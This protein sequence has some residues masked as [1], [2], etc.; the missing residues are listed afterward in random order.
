M[1]DNITQTL[2]TVCA[3]IFKHQQFKQCQDALQAFSS[4]LSSIPQ[5]KCATMHEQPEYDVSWTSPQSA[6]VSSSTGQVHGELAEICPQLSSALSISLDPST[7]FV[8]DFAFR[9]L[10]GLVSFCFSDNVSSI[11]EAC[12]RDD[13][14]L[15]HVVLP[16]NLKVVLNEA[17]YNCSKLD[18][19]LHQCIQLEAIADDAFSYCKSLRNVVLPNGIEVVGAAFQCCGDLDVVEIPSTLLALDPYAFAGTHI[20]E[21]KGNVALQKFQATFRRYAYERHM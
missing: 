17:F 11:S 7:T 3:G 4:C 18:V 19:D 12:F 1:T 20:S 21:L 8:G 9:R 6:I 14:N 5:L 13:I 2:K 16:K 10:S 15:Q